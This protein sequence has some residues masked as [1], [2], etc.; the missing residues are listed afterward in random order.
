MQVNALPRAMPTPTDMNAASGRTGTATGAVAL[1][2]ALLALPLALGGC[3]RHGGPTTPAP[4]A[5]SARTAPKA[6]AGDDLALADVLRTMAPAVTVGQRSAPV[7]ARY[8]LPA[9]PVAGQ[10]FKLE[11]AVLPQAASPLVRVE[12]QASEGLKL[13]DPAAAQSLER[14]QAGA[15]LRIPVTAQ[16][17]APGTQVIDIGV[18]LE[19]PTGAESRAFAIPVIVAGAAGK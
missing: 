3:H 7:E 10:P 4:S 12:L 15:V 8:D 14:V 19:L 11:L 9:A 13:L 6:D 2:L 18:T 1:G 5:A 16:A 17:S